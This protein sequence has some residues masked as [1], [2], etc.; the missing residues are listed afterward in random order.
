MKLSNSSR[1]VAYSGKF[2]TLVLLLAMLLLMS[3]TVTNQCP[4]PPIL[5][6]FLHPSLIH[7]RTL[8]DRLFGRKR[9]P[10]FLDPLSVDFL[11]R[12]PEMPKIPERGSLASSS[13]FDDPS[14]PQTAE[15]QP[16]TPNAPSKPVRNPAIM[17]AALDPTPHA[18]K[19]WQRKMVIRDVRGRHRMSKTVHIART[20][21]TSLSKS[22]MFKTSVKKLGPLARQIAGKPIEDAILQMRF[23]KKKAA[24]DVKHHLE[25][26]RN[27]AIAKRGM[28]LVEVNAMEDDKETT[29]GADRKKKKM[30]VLVDKHGKRR[31]ITDRTNI[32]IDQAWVG[33]GSY[34]P[35]PEY[36]ARGRV[37]MLRHPTPSESPFHHPHSRSPPNDQ[38]F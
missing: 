19:R 30:I 7:R 18:R 37:N 33:R 8:F 4:H 29:P 28:G 32:Y 5:S 16:V 13:I 24:R 14:S 20:E 11:K 1:R 35:E 2:S 12:K 23:S 3:N 22:P 26:A 25:Y 9:N 17:A 38:H 27:E 21:R 6:P 36:R 10:Q 31:V 15:Q 34:T